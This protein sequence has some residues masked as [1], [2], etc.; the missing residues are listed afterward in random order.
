MTPNEQW[1]CSSEQVRRVALSNLNID[2]YDVKKYAK[3]RF[4]QIPANIREQLK[5]RHERGQ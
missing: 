3:L 2:L 4:E 5:R 1:D